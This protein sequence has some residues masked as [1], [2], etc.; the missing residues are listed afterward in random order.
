ML[1]RSDAEGLITA[2][3][4]AASAAEIAVIVVGTNSKVESEGYDRENLDLPGRQDDLVRAVVATGTPT[5]VVVNAGSPVVLPWADDVAAVMQGYFGGQEFG[6]A[7]AA[8]LTGGA[9]PGGRLPTTWP[10]ALADVPVTEVTPSKGALRYTEGI[11]I[12][13]RAWLK[14]DA[15]PA[16]PFG[17]GLGYTTWSWDTVQRDDDAVKVTL[18]NTGHRAGKQVVQIY[19]QRGDSAL[20]RPA[21]WLVGYAVVRAD[22]GETVTARIALPDRRFAHWNE[23]WDIEPGVFTLRAGASIA[24]LPLEL[25]WTAE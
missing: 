17:H 4:A 23:G 7:L 12:G 16:F 22:A 14:S 21:R 5:I 13:Y 24:D 11:H 9:E 25:G 19:A 6:S 18:T 20:E 8:V 1:F 3:V 15:Q 2:A 10:V